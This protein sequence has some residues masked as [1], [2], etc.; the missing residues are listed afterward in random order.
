VSRNPIVAA[1]LAFGL[2][3]PALAL[4]AAWAQ[5]SAVQPAPVAA[6]AF[7][8]VTWNPQSPQIKFSETC[9]VAGEQVKCNGTFAVGTVNGTG[10]FIG[11]VRDNTWVGIGSSKGTESDPKCRLSYESRAGITRV[12]N[13]DGT[14]TTTA[15]DS[16][17]NYFS[18][19]G[20]CA[21]HMPRTSTDPGPTTT[22]GTWRLIALSD[23][24]AVAENAP[25]TAPQTVIVIAPDGRAIT[26]NLD[27]WK[28]GKL[29]VEQ[30]ELV[31]QFEMKPPSGGANYTLQAFRYPG[32]Q[33]NNLPVYEPMRRLDDVMAEGAYNAG[34]SALACAQGAA[35]WAKANPAKAS[36]MA[37]SLA[38]SLAMPYTVAFQ[39][40]AGGMTFLESAGIGFMTSA[41]PA[42][43][44]TLVTSAASGEGFWTSSGKA[45]KSGG[46]A[47]VE[48]FVSTVVGAGTTGVV[49]TG[50]ALT[51]RLV[52]ARV[53]EQAVKGFGTVA[54][55]IAGSATDYGVGILHDQAADAIAQSAAKTT[56][57][58]LVPPARS[59]PS[60]GIVLPILTRNVAR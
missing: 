5:T 49:E 32:L 45:V 42:A 1:L 12:L 38:V 36:L 47:G 4:P 39:A 3:V 23:V 37:L 48:S 14:Q 2:F 44:Q 58:D 43:V 50:A 13:P 52:G 46:I 59:T 24:P 30:M 57:P 6:A 28:G 40:S 31:K 9:V 55:G 35:S 18:V 60:G 8:I 22:V 20:A 15:V 56:I 16:T 51:Q 34:T 33:G 54:S 41:T 10:M 29:T 53:S 11:K 26:I 7:E 19:S 21:P 17:V 25:A 27:D